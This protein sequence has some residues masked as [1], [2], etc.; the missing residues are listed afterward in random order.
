MKNVF[1]KNLSTLTTVIIMSNSKVN[2]ISHYKLSC[3][4]CNKP[5]NRGDEITQCLEARGMEMRRVP[6]SGSRW[7][8]I[9]CVPKDITTLY[10]LNA[11]KELQDDYPDY[12]EDE[13]MD[14]VE[15]HDY[16]TFEENNVPVWSIPPFRPPTPPRQSCNNHSTEVYDSTEEDESSEEC[17]SSEE[18]CDSSEED[19]FEYIDSY[20]G[21]LK[22]DPE[23]KKEFE[24]TVDETLEML[25]EKDESVRGIK[26]LCIQI[27][28]TLEWLREYATD[29]QK[30]SIAR[31]LFG[32]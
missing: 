18:E 23:E 2:C 16:W 1:F 31:V 17:D 27:E 30:N 10:Y 8:H 25:N 5:I 21:K 20:F 11:I 7:V 13:I 12:D 29:K 15:N 28:E 22:I 24:N 26:E 4:V 6:Y 19:C 32:N 3:F 9:L 14:I